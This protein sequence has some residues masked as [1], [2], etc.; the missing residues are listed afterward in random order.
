VKIAMLGC[1]GL[2]ATYGGVE[3]HIEE[4]GARLVERGHEVSVYCRPHYGGRSEGDYYRGM[5]R[6]VLPGIPSRRLDALSHTAVAAVHA[7]REGYD[8]VHYHAVG[9]GVVSPLSRAAAR[10]TVVLTVHGLDFA[11]EKWGHGARMAL[12]A[13]ARLSAF[14]P[15]RTIVVAQSLQDFYRQRYGVETVYV[16]NGVTA[17]GAGSLEQLVGLGV[18]PEDYLLSVGRLVPEKGVHLLLEAYA[19][20]SADRPRL[21]VVGGDSFTGDYVAQVTAQA[22]ALPDVDLPGYVY[23]EQL[24]SAYANARLFVQSSTL[25]GMPLTVLEAAAHDRPLVLSDIPVHVQL[26][27]SDRP[28]GRLFRSGSADSLR[29]AL[30]R[31]LSDPVSEALGARRV[32]AE[33]RERFS[34]DRTV[35]GTIEAYEQ[36]LGSARPGALRS[37]PTRVVGVGRRRSAAAR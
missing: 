22:A 35:D 12:Q 16:P 30:Q 24:Q 21:L 32:G 6:I 23:G 5:R 33:L 19:G 37:Q 4:I 26:L 27:G 8:I 7:A 14:V 29:Q 13:S 2:P 31:A 1:R 9:P 3:R 34:W 15:S 11:R 20:L 10:G 36:A 18:E 28:G 17:A 25:E